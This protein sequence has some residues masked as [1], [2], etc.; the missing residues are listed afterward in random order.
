MSDAAYFRELARRCRLLSETAPTR[1]SAA[2]L[3]PE[4]SKLSRDQRGNSLPNRRPKPERQEQ[5]HDQR[6]SYT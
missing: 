4:R 1:R 6:R 2:L 5:D 3:S